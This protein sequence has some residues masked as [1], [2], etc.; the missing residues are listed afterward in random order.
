MIKTNSVGAKTA[1][2]SQWTYLP[3][4]GLTT[5]LRIMEPP[6]NDAAHRR[7]KG[8]ARF[9]GCVP[10]LTPSDLPPPAV[11]LLLAGFFMAAHQPFPELNHSNRANAS[12]V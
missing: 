1:I 10:G 7:A 3:N 6:T 11:L 4:S 8:Q 2:Q 12:H 5:A 9:A